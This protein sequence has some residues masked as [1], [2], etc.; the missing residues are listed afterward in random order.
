MIQWHHITEVDHQWW[1]KDLWFIHCWVI[2]WSNKNLPSIESFCR[3]INVTKTK[4]SFVLFQQNHSKTDICKVSGI[5]WKGQGVNH[6]KGLLNLTYIHD[7]PMSSWN[8]LLIKIL[9]LG[10]YFIKKILKKEVPQQWHSAVSIILLYFD[11][12]CEFY[13][14]DYWYSL[15]CDLSRCL[16]H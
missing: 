2:S 14:P 5:S 13:L 15:Q 12:L 10:M 4:I 7:L 3:N 9:L 16:A 11:V 6:L 8:Y 1:D